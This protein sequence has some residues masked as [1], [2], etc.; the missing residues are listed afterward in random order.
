MQRAK[1]GTVELEYDVL[2]TGEPLLMI[3]GAHIADA[4][5]PLAA[6]PALAGFQR[7]VYHRR[8]FAGSTHVPGPTTADAQTTDAVG[9]LDHLGIDRV[10]V[11]GHSAGAVIALALAA[12]APA[13]LRSLVVLEPALPDAPGGEDFLTV[14][15]PVVERY[16][17]GDGAGAADDFLALVGDENWRRVIERSV[18]GGVEQAEKDAATFFE[19]E[20]PALAAFDS[21]HIASVSVPV[22]AVI[23]TASAP[24][25]AASRDRLHERIPH[26]T[27]ADIEGLNH[28]LQ[29]QDAGAVAAAIAPFLAR[30]C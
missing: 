17:S 23:G 30:A 24:I 22:L 2:G 1:I 28:L 19:S 8:G 21:A 15:G 3:H 9:L 26:C 16:T 6:E 14:L 5:R 4:M 20:L 12:A 7:I 29:M 13:R 18:P 25:F 10:H 27:D 11:V